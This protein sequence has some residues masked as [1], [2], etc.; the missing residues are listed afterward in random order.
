MSETQTIN[1]D[2]HLTLINEG[3]NQRGNQWF[4]YKKSNGTFAFSYENLDGKY[5]IILML[6]F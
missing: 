6:V 5:K 4:V 2:A 1:E 3:V